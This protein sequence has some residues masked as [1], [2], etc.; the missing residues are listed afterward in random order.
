VNELSQIVLHESHEDATYQYDTLE[1]A[2]QQTFGLCTVSVM[3]VSFRVGDDRLECALETGPCFGV[4][5][6]REQRGAVQ[7]ECVAT[8]RCFVAACR[9]R[10]RVRATAQGPR[11]ASR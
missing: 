3:P 1:H 2:M 8:F 11:A 10:P 7:I 4:L 6:F 5:R 9:Q